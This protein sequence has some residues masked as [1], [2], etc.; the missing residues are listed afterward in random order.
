MRKFF[1]AMFVVI[2]IALAYIIFTIENANNEQIAGMIYLFLTSI[3]ALYLNNT[4]DL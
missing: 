3:Y 4:S 1:N 2:L